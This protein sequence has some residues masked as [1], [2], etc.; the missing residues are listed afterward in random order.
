[1]QRKIAPD[2][3][4]MESESEK[5]N[6]SRKWKSE[7]GWGKAYHQGAQQVIVIPCEEWMSFSQR[8]L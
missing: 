3:A 1:M 6:K 4:R 5:K 7:S 2:D 8:D